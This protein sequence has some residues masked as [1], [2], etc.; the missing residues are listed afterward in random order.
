MYRMERVVLLPCLRESLDLAASIT[1]IRNPNP[2]PC[3]LTNS[4]L[5][6]SNVEVSA[7][8][9]NH[10]AVCKS[11]EKSHPGS[12]EEISPHFIGKLKGPRS[13]TDFVDNKSKYFA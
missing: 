3:N 6:Q 5:F 9:P 10:A 11:V 4:N 8:C 13:F 7:S 2:Y 12:N 1:S